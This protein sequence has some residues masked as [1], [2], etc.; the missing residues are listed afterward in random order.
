MN[1]KATDPDRVGPVVRAGL[2]GSGIGVLMAVCG[3]IWSARGRG[4]GLD[5]EEV[6]MN[7]LAALSTGAIVGMVLHLTKDYR[8][9]GKLQHYFSWVLACNVAAFIFLV[10]A[11]PE[12]GWKAT[13]RLSLWLGSVVG[14]GLG[15]AARQVDGH[16]W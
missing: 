7:A 4:R 14:L 5:W 1:N 15:L 9:R 12:D 8:A 16:R 3:T 13:I 10:P 6:Q 11:I 2:T